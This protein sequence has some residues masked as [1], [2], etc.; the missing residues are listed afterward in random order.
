MG[1]AL[2]VGLLADL[3][4][5]DAEGYDAFSENFEDV[6]RLLAA[7]SL[8]AHTEPNDVEPWGAEMY[9]YSSL[10]YL[11][12]L[13]AYVDSGMSLPEPGGSN[14]SE[15]PRLEA[16]FQ[17]VTG[18]RRGWLRRLMQSRSSF[19]REFD[20]L[21]VHSDAEGFYLPQDFVHVLFATSDAEVP[22]GMVGST[23]RFY[24]SVSGWREYSRSHRTSQRTPKN[25]GRLLILRAKERLCGSA[26]ESSH[27][28]A[29]PC[30]RLAGDH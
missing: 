19:R 2:S 7:H 20:H 30:R 10:H 21:I 27:S 18:Q 23:P 14:S 3:K 26:T 8:P 24:P 16:Y 28:H 22:G 5:N 12:R 11:R 25:F 17:D 4:E 15:D 9:G 13:A 6:N 1:L 29:L